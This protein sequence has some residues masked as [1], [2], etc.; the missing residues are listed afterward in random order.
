MPAAGVVHDHRGRPDRAGAR[1]TTWS[2]R[3]SRCAKITDGLDEAIAGVGRDHREERAGRRG[4]DRRSTRTSTPASTLLEGLLV[5]KAGHGGRRRAWSTGCTRARPAS[6]LR[7]FPESTTIKAPRISEVYTK[8]TLTLARLGREAPIAA[9][10]P[11]GPALRNPA[12]GSLA[13]RGAVPGDPADA[14]GVAAA[15]AGHRHRLAGP[16]RA[17][18]VARR[19]QADAGRGAQRPEPARAAW[20]VGLAFLRRLRERATDDKEIWCRPPRHLSTS[21]RPASKARSRR[22][23]RL[24][25]EAR[26]IAGG[27]SLLPMMKLRLA[28]P[29]YLID[30]NDLDELVLHPT[31]GSTRSGSAR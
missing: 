31:S 15:L 4:R 9:A 27:H 14:P 3:S 17:E 5:K 30:I 29:E 21:A 26:L 16:V 19:A 13:A 28:N 10:S 18:R 24:G 20:S 7:N 23:Q 22:S 2:R 12:Y 8:G 11:N 6:G 25:P 1:R